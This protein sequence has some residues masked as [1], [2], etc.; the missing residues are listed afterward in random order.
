[1]GNEV[2]PGVP[3]LEGEAGVVSGYL[4]REDV[5]YLLIVEY[6]RVGSTVVGAE[7]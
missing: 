2:Q 1:M 5:C 4:E 6:R 3:K 7:G